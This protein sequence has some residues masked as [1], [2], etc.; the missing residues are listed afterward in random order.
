MTT[1]KQQSK[2]PS[3][4]KATKQASNGKKTVAA[5]RS[6]ASAT[7]NAVAADDLALRAWQKTYENRQ[8]KLGSA[9]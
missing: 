3:T 8:R 7:K 1:K 6:G 4:V 2:K 9:R 5:N